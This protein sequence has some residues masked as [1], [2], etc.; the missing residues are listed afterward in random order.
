[1]W[2]LY[3]ER[4]LLTITTRNTFNMHLTYIIMRLTLIQRMLVLIRG[5]QILF[6]HLNAMKKPVGVISRV[7]SLITPTLSLMKGMGMLFMLLN[8]IK[9]HI[10]LMNTL[11]GSSL[12]KI[13]IL[14]NG[15]SL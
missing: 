1:M 14:A 2:P 15:K 7:F 3:G 4:K 8:V 13:F 11:F 9:R 12:I 6:M 10:M 5:E